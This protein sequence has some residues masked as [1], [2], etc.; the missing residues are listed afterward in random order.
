MKGEDVQKALNSDLGIF[1]PDPEGRTSR[2]RITTLS[3]L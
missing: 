2:V 3:L 1:D